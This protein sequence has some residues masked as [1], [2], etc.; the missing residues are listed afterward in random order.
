MKEI[1]IIFKVLHDYKDMRIKKNLHVES[2]YFE[3]SSCIV[4]LAVFS[5]LID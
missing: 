3:N 4:E 2:S 5:L 1:G